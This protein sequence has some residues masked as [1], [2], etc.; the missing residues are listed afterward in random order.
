MKKNKLLIILII[1]GFVVPIIAKK[2][3]IDKQ[4]FYK[5]KIN[6]CKILSQQSK[7]RINKAIKQSV[8]YTDYNNELDKYDKLKNKQV[9]WSVLLNQIMEKLPESIWLEEFTAH[10]NKTKKGKNVNNSYNIVLSGKATNSDTIDEF[11]STIKNINCLKNVKLKTLDYTNLIW[12]FE[13][14]SVLN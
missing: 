10:D 12:H 1:V 3:I 4:Q 7:F 6:E 13:V 14:I 8:N 11:V 9:K 5:N 2:R